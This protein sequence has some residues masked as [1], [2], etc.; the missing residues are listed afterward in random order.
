MSEIRKLRVQLTNEIRLNVP[1]ANITVDPEMAP[2][3]DLQSKL[4]RQILLSGMGDQVAKKISPEN[5][6][7]GE[8][9]VSVYNL[10]S[11]FVPAQ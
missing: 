1:D 7:D 6:P 4:L 11:F 10:G 9:K 8:D 3:D 2:P 5:V